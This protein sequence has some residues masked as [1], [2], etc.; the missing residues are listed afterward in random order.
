MA[1]KPKAGFW[2]VVILVVLGLG[3]YALYKAGILA[4]EGTTGKDAGKIDKDALNQIKTPDK[5]AAEAPDSN[6]PTTRQGVHL[7]AGGQA[8]AGQGHLELQAHGGQHRPVRAQRLGR[9]GADHVGQP[10]LQGGSRVDRTPDGK[11]F[12]VELVLIDDPVA[13]R[14]AYATGKVHIGWATLDMMPLFME[15]LQQGH[16]GHAA[17]LP[18]DRLVQ[19]RRRH[20]RPRGRRDTSAELR[21]KTI[22]LA[23]NSPFPLLRAQR[24]DQRRASSRPR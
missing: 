4:P 19:R 6:A 9:L 3:G 15:E 8:A 21:G 10:G 16:P 24:A 5:N 12:K 2:V 20:R 11:K 1:G 17:D 14:D 13:M 23:Q 7:R 22:V 18:A